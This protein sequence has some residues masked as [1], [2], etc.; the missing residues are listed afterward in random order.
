MCKV[1]MVE[2]KF[3]YVEIRAGIS[4]SSENLKQATWNA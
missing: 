1:E 4:P 3:I 2:I